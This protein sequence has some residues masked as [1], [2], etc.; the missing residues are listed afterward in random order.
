MSLDRDRTE[1]YPDMIDLMH[2]PDGI[3]RLNM[4]F[5]PRISSPLKCGYDSI[6]P[7]T[8]VRHSRRHTNE[9]VRHDKYRHLHMP[10]QM[11]RMV[12][13]TNGNR[14]SRLPWRYKQPA[15][16]GRI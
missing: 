2:P 9:F 8:R 4:D 5:G 15:G 11:Q 16:R 3:R 10:A 13:A 7:G 14:F 12:A 6:D 1:G